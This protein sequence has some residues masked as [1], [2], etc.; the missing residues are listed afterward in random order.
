MATFDVTL[1]Y[2]WEKVLTKEIH[3]KYF[4]DIIN[5]LNKETKEGKTVYPSSSLIFNAFN[6]TPFN[7]IKVVIIGQDPYHG[8]GQA[9]G[10]SFSVPK[11]IRVPPSLKN[12]YKELHSDI[13]FNI[14]SHG[15]LTP[16]AKEGVFLLNAM[17]S[18]EHKKPGSHKK[19]GWQQFTNK[20]ISLISEHHSGIVFMLWG[21]FAQGKKEFIDSEKHMILEAAHPSPL[22]RGAFFG[23]KHFSKCNSYLISNNKKPVSWSL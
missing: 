18:V 6:L 21:N 8:P 23:N 20:V 14:P 17:L 9:M 19:I 10:L 2:F 22:A 3:K 15:D 1:E 7:K 16:W 12:I 11:D 5:F 13:Q 4:L